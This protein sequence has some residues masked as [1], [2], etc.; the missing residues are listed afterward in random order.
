VGSFSWG[1]CRPLEAPFVRLVAALGGTLTVRSRSWAGSRVRRCA[2]L[3]GGWV[4]GRRVGVMSGVGRAHCW[5]LRQPAMGRGFHDAGR[6]WV[7]YRLAAAGS[8]HRKVWGLWWWWGWWR[9]RR[10]VRP[11]LENCTVDASIPDVQRRIT[12][13]LRGGEAFSWISVAYL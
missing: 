2:A 3:R 12:F 8:S 10:R 6:R 4:V 11:L 9:P 13:L 7:S 1:P 5:V